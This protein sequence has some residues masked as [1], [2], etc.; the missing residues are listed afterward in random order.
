MELCTNSLLKALRGL[1]I[2]HVRPHR[3][4]HLCILFVLCAA[5]SAFSQMLL[6]LRT[7]DYV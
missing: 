5:R 4:V 3:I 1:E 2:L 6:E 7:V